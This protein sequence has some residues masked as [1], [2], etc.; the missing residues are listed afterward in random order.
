[1]HFQLTSDTKDSLFISH[2]TLSR[3]SSGNFQVLLGLIGLLWL[4]AIGFFILRKLFPHLAP[5]DSLQEDSVSSE[6]AKDQN[7]ALAFL[8]SEA[9]SV[10][11]PPLE[12]PQEEEW[13]LEIQQVLVESYADPEF[14]LKA[15]AEEMKLRQKKVDEIFRAKVKISFETFLLELRLHHSSKLLMEFE[16]QSLEVYEKVGFKSLRQFNKAFKVKFNKSPEKFYLTSE[17]SS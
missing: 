14:S 17:E 1:M 8:D 10:Q 3:N 2:I 15:L 7:D 11:L 6:G 12:D 4:L 9:P 5:S 16:G 13:W